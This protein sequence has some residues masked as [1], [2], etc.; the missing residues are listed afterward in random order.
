MI[1]KRRRENEIARNRRMEIFK[2]YFN[3]CRELTILPQHGAITQGDLNWLEIDIAISKDK[4]QRNGEF[5][6][7]NR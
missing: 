4:K 1:E 5:Q 3:A 6:T 7:S 2:R